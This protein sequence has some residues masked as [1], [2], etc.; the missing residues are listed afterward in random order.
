MSGALTVAELVAAATRGDQRAWDAIVTRYLPLVMHTVGK[1]RLSDDDAE[2]VNQTVWLRLVEHLDKI[3][4]PE[5]LP[6]WIVTTTRNEAYRV[7][8]TRRRTV[9]VDPQTSTEL[10]V[11]CGRGAHE[12]DL[13]REE[14]RQALRDGLAELKPHQRELLQLLLADPPLSYDAISKRLGISI[15]SIGPTRARS[16]EQLRKTSALRSLMSADSSSDFRR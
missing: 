6:A 13:L 8:A 5:A 1:L 11:A 9:A 10:E 16:L 15:G 14:R 7:L 12:D 2:D 3:R 4:E